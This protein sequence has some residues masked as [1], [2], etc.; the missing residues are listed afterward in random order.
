MTDMHDNAAGQILHQQR[1]RMLTTTVH[2]DGEELPATPRRYFET[3][4]RLGHVLDVQAIT[5]AADDGGPLVYVGE[6]SLTRSGA[7]AL[8]DYLGELLAV[9]ES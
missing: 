2:V 1:A 3:A 7:A 9:L 6:A 4:E 8:R 5:G